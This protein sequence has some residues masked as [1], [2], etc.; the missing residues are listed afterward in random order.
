MSP[1]KTLLFALILAAILIYIRQV[2]LPQEEAKKEADLLF[3]GVKETEVQA[4]TIKNEFGS[5][6]LINTAPTQPKAK[7]EKSSGE[8]P[9]FSE[10]PAGKWELADIKSEKLDSGPLTQLL[11]TITKIQLEGKISVQDQEKDL[12]VYGLDKPALTVTVKGP[13]GTTELV[14]GKE[15]EYVGKHYLTVSGKEGIYLV[16][17]AL[18]EAANKKRN[19]FR[20]KTPFQFSDYDLQSVTIDGTSGHMK[21][22]QTGDAKW[23]IVEPGPYSGN[24]QAISDLLH[25]ARIIRVSDYIDPA[26][27][28][29]QPAEAEFGLN[30][31]ALKLGL[32]FKETSKKP[33]LDFIFALKETQAV[34]QIA[35]NPVVYKLDEKGFKDLE[36]PVE[37]FREKQFVRFD[38]DGVQKAVFERAGQEALVISNAA[39]KWTVNGQEGDLPFIMQ[40]LRN[41]SDLSAVGYPR[42]E[43]D[44]GFTT[45][46]VKITVTVKNESSG[47]K[48][49]KGTKDITLVVGS[50]AP[51]DEAMVDGKGVTADYA[52]VGDLT[53][54]F[55]I[56]EE[57]LK[58]ITPRAESLV[59]VQV[60][61]EATVAASPAETASPEDHQ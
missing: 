54:P 9:V 59:K 56:S 2:E 48:T 36:K 31:P 27:D 26:A 10:I 15:N 16:N 7:E 42:S 21:F 22:E 1:K 23:K 37:A 24:T 8:T 47:D 49:D 12:A 28:G 46:A 34:G 35:G 13:K 57:A 39:G 33:H 58:K 18:Y 25:D 6:E 5:F 61:P 55:L 43:R 40:V 44:Y 14:L 19:D 17:T 52:A 45:P 4:L 41:V 30:T 29:S 32:D 38:A 3:P 11:T 51:A 60:S 53:E 20:D 50:M